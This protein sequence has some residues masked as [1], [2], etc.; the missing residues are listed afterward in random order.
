MR[1][2]FGEYLFYA[3]HCRPHLTL[4]GQFFIQHTLAK[5]TLQEYKRHSL[6]APRSYRLE[7]KEIDIQTKE[8]LATQLSNDR[9]VPRAPGVLLGD[10]ARDIGRGHF[11]ASLSRSWT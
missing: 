10:A 6:L 9:H 7:G 5:H 1:Q 8:S 2:T 11:Q 3:V 4:L